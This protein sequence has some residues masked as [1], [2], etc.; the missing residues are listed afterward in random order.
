MWLKGSVVLARPG[1]LV[2]GK[3]QLQLQSVEKPM[4]PLFGGAGWL[5]CGVS[6]VALLLVVLY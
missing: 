5:W 3:R 2:R 6:T 1:Q 4:D